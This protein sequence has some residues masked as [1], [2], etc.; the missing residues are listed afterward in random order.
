RTDDAVDFDEVIAWLRRRVPVSGGRPAIIHNDFKLDNL[1]W[2]ES[3]PTQLSAVLDW[4]MATVGDSL[5]DL[6][7]TLSF[8]VEPGDP[9]E[10]K[11]LRNMPTLAPGSPSRADAIAHYSRR[12]GLSLADI[13]FYLCFGFFRRAV[14]E[15]QKYARFVRGDTDDPRY[16]HLDASVQVLRE[17]CQQYVRGEA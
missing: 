12:T 17:I 1:V 13:D 16:A 7:C 2:E 10:L 11:A 4:E 15:Q 14:I 6:A 5:M 8:W 9:A 3:N